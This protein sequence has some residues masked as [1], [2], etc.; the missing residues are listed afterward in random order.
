MDDTMDLRSQVMKGIVTAI[1]D[2]GQ[3]QMATVQLDDMGSRATVEVMQRFG[4]TAAGERVVSD[5]NGQR[6][7]FR[8]GGLA[9]IHVGTM[10]TITAP[11]VTIQ[12]PR[13]ADA[14]VTIT[15]TLVVT[16]DISD[17][18]GVHGTLNLLRTDYNEHRHPPET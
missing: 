14:N 4:K 10:L 13:G 15:G 7:H 1:D 8:N 3:A 17:K 9:E 16:Q 5:C 2:T 18:N 11:A 12:G 6:L